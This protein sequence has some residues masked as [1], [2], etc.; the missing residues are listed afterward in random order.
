M[1]SIPF[2]PTLLCLLYL[3]LLLIAALAV[4]S[5][6]AQ[7]PT[8][9]EP[10]IGL[11]EPPPYEVGQVLDMLVA[12]RSGSAD[13]LNAVLTVTASSG[14]TFLS[15]TA[16]HPTQPLSCS[17]NNAQ[18][19]VC[20][21]DVVRGITEAII[22]IRFD[23]PGDQ[24][25]TATVSQSNPDPNEDNNTLS[26]T[27]PVEGEVATGSISGTKWHDED[28]DGQHDGNEPGLAG[29]TIYVDENGNGQLDG[30]EPSAATGSD[31]S[32][33][34]DGL[35]PDTYTVR[36]ALQDGWTQTF[37]AGG[38]HTVTVEAGTTT[39][40]VDFGNYQMAMTMADLGVL[41]NATSTSA[42]KL[43]EDDTLGVTAGDTLDV[44][45]QVDNNGPDT[46][47]G[48]TITLRIDADG[49]VLVIDTETVDQCEGRG[50]PNFP[51]GESV[52]WDIDQLG[53]GESVDC[54]IKIFTV[55]RGEGTING[56]VTAT[57][58]DP[59]LS[60][61]T[62]GLFT[63]VAEQK[64][65]DLAVDKSVEPDTVLVGER[66]TYTVSILNRGPDDATNVRI[67][68]I[69]FSDSLEFIQA[70]APA[71][72]TVTQNNGQLD[73][74]L[75]SLA[76]GQT[77]SFAYQVLT[78]LAGKVSNLVD[79]TSDQNDPDVENNIKTAVAYVSGGADLSVEKTVSS[80]TVGLGA[81][82]F[83]TVTV[84][85]NGPET[86]FL[87]ET[88]DLVFS[89]SLDY[90]AASVPLNCDL[91]SATDD[92]TG[93][94]LAT[95]T[96]RI[97]AI[98]DPG[99]SA[100]VDYRAIAKKAGT[101]S[102]EV[103]VKGVP[104][105]L[106]PD[107]NIAT[108]STFVENQTAIDFSLDA[109]ASTDN[110]DVG[111]RVRFNFSCTANEPA[112]TCR[113]T[114][115]TN[116]DWADPSLEGTFFIAGGDT[117]AVAE[118]D[119]MTAEI[120]PE[121]FPSGT[122]RVTYTFNGGYAEGGETYMGTFT[123]RADK[124]NPA[125]SVRFEASTPNNDDPNTED[126]IIEILVNIDALA[127]AIEEEPDEV[128][129]SFRLHAN[130]PNPFNP[131]TTIRFD[132]ART[133]PVRLAVY[134]LLGR[135]VAVLV[136]AQKPAGAYSVVFDARDLASGIYLYQLKSDGF[137]QTRRLVL[138]K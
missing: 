39:T 41:V 54:K 122:T 73:C 127:T 131:E 2:R 133:T 114:A 101:V 17:L 113:V 93:K 18:E 137:T 98:L 7:T 92:D 40:G 103:E 8:D 82:L 75:G 25:L 81:T 118:G 61:N 24:T 19:V 87:I 31:G 95:M 85:N 86:A 55:E 83:Y 43:A 107:N 48:I 21:R 14:V 128:P 135:E 91:G 76:A 44:S 38:A 13:A 134:D 105:D 9:S 63:T 71:G 84:T 74:T 42:G 49:N 57:T 99:E 30:G 10:V 6:W 68:D 34:I 125:A 126:D 12:F 29:W 70:S 108:V 51:D 89:D 97:A 112:S 116:D 104:R 115:T 47:E 67:R 4:P 16:I 50:T 27:V 129:R 72:C 138:L 3:S 37:P 110:A 53:D 35:D 102:N 79:A 36:E 28:Q 124:P 60:N 23:A 62:N 5:S 32:Y 136:D 117:M 33:Q 1:R 119:S 69:V 96:C 94:P 109:S 46:A 66:L 78:K 52:R 65:A 11:S 130:Y 77:T 132:V 58:P 123:L 111:D 22:K 120:D 56:T 64:M 80:D 15:V 45:V 106:N 90:D 121:G 59:D 26:G 88:D 100:T 20:T